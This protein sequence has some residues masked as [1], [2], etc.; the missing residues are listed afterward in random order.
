[1]KGWTDKNIKNCS[2]FK[3]GD[4]KIGTEKNWDT[5]KLGDRKIEG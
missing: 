3:R 4:R 1:M 5:E 2:Y